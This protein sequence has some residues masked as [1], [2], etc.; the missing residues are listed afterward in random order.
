LF[1][2]DFPVLRD[3]EWGIPLGGW[4][5]IR[6][7]YPLR[8]VPVIFVHGNHSDAV[9]WFGVADQFKRDAGYT[10]Q[11]TWAISYNGLGGQVDGAPVICN[12]PPSP[13]ATAYWQRP[14]VAGN[15]ATA[16]QYAADDVNVPDLYAFIRAVQHYT[17]STRVQLVGHSLGVTIIRKTMFDHRQLYREVTAA[18]S[19]A[20]G[21]HGT[22]LCRGAES[23]LYGCNE[24]AP[25]TAWLNRLNSIGETPGPT[26][27]MSIYNGTNNLDPFFIQTATYDDRRSPHLRGAINLT[28]PAAY[29][30][31]LRVRP[32]IIASYLRFLQASGTPQQPPRTPVDRSAGEPAAPGHGQPTG[33]AIGSLATTGGGR[34][35][36]LVALIVVAGALG[37]GWIRRR[38]RPQPH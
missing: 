3:C 25:D 34:G 12:C 17:G 37:I 21:N 26:K 9:D 30:S 38:M 7:G 16:G 33:S 19:I 36:G 1:A 10:D 14:D 20:G 6:R 27:W 32:D 29:H 15:L 28:Y 11:E 18:V 8:H 5:G 2:K 13:R 4:G 31:D 22:S 23:T 35:L 24:I